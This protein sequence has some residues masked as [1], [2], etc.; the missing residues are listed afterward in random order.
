MLP[1]LEEAMA[2]EISKTRHVRQQAER[3]HQAASIFELA[4]EDAIVAEQAP[5]V[6]RRGPNR[7]RNVVRMPPAA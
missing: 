4:D 2:D 5:A 3:L 6:E 7:A 1:V